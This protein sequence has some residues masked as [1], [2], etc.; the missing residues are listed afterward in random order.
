MKNFAPICVTV[1]EPSTQEGW[2]ELKRRVAVVHAD[3]VLSSI[4]K[5]DC[6]ISEKERLLRAMIQDTKEQIKTE[7]KKQSE[8]P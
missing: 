1:H 4:S 8:K 2:R 6:S 3:A 5:L 7:R